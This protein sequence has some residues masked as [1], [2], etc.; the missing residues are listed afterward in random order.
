MKHYRGVLGEFSFDPTMFELQDGNLIY[1]GGT[2][3]GCIKCQIPEGIICCDRMFANNHQI[4]VGP[5][6]PKSCISANEM[7][8]NCTQLVVYP[9]I[10]LALMQSNE[11]D[12]T[13]MFEGCTK[14]EQMSV[15]TEGN[16]F[17]SW[18][19]ACEYSEDYLQHVHNMREL[20]SAENDRRKRT[21]PL[22]HPF[23]NIVNK[24]NGAADKVNEIMLGTLQ[25]NVTFSLY[26][27]LVHIVA[28][29]KRGIYLGIIPKRS[30]RST[31]D[32]KGNY[33][34]ESAYVSEDQVAARGGSNL[35]P[36]KMR[37]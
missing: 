17:E 35:S 33:I 22:R 15:D 5:V 7:F 27:E 36:E 21:Y 19:C 20:V 12:C 10:N 16:Q 34:D 9:D 26:P 4:S 32:V 25:H 31:T 37:V 3:Y 6:L 24:H 29:R 28:Q 23:K 14:L 8:K 18:I 11:F 13:T 2:H 30:K 1:V